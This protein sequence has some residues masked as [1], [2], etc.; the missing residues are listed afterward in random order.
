MIK[1]NS[2]MNAVLAIPLFGM[3]QAVLDYEL[4][5][6]QGNKASVLNWIHDHSNVLSMEST[7]STKDLGKYMLVI[8]RE[9][10]DIVEDYIDKILQQIPELDKNPTPF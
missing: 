4:I 9:C 1:Q 2:E 5:D 6:K 7:A 3:T 8:D 10:K